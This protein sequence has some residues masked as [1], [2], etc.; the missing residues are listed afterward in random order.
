MIGD[1]LWRTLGMF[2]EL[3]CAEDSV[4]RMWASGSFLL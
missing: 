2:A 4:W 3:K 1:A